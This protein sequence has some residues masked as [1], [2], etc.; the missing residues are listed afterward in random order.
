MRFSDAYVAFL[1]FCRYYRGKLVVFSPPVGFERNKPWE[2]GERQAR[3]ENSGSADLE[4]ELLRKERKV[5]QATPGAHLQVGK[6]GRR[7]KKT[8]SFGL[9]EER[10]KGEITRKEVSDFTH[11]GGIHFVARISQ[12][13]K[14]EI[15]TGSFTFSKAQV[16]MHGNLV[17][18]IRS[19]VMK[20]HTFEKQPK[21]LQKNVW[22]I[23]CET[24]C[25][26]WTLHAYPT[27]R[28]AF[29]KTSLHEVWRAAG[30]LYFLG[31]GTLSTSA[32]VKVFVFLFLEFC[33]RKRAW[34]GGR[35]S[36]HVC[37]CVCMWGV[38]GL[39]IFMC[40]CNHISPLLILLLLFY[41]VVKTIK[42]C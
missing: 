39:Y 5:R 25:G 1:R 29:F 36:V 40:M 38:G 41:R 3:G 10:R 19:T 7:K 22:F 42:F 16:E 6:R 30:S 11:R 9:C 32:D 4:F 34:G 18:E 20:Q 14:F 17:K 2:G 8:L 26:R 12:L 24:S 28:C 15:K 35:V 13:L 31:W 21:R 23:L 27:D 33:Y 37:V